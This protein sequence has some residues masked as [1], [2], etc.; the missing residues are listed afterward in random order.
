MLTDKLREGAQ[1]RIFKI[2]FWI[3]ILS[4]IFTGVGGYL[5]PRLN[6]DP[7]EVGEYK[8]TANEWNQQY[9]SQT[10]QMQRMYGARFAD[11]LEDPQYVSNLRSQILEGM[12]DNV[13]FNSA[14]YD[15][16]V[17]I[18]DEQVRELIRTTPAFQKDGKETGG[19]R[20]CGRRSVN[21]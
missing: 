20:T 1:G 11:M 16:N 14:V 15:L 9:T 17:R 7:V 19:R 2:L 4:F 13:A 5:I 21:R 12:I 8:I 3:I 10:Q 18:G 6:T